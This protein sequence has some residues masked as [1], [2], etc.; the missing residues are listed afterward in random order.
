[1]IRLVDSDGDRRV[2]RAEFTYLWRVLSQWSTFYLAHAGPHPVH[3]P[4]MPLTTFSFF[5]RDQ[6][7]AM[8]SPADGSDEQ[9]RAKVDAVVELV[10]ESVAGRAQDF[11]IMSDYYTTQASLALAGKF[12]FEGLGIT[13]LDM[14]R[15]AFYV[16]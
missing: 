4:V 3:G 12:A 7:R 16:R 15:V 9:L 1:M 2:S 5:L 10:C 13:K 6:L 11:L 8:R 14:V